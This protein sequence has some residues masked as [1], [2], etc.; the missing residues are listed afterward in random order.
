MANM[1]RIKLA[2]S[3]MAVAF[4]A[5]LA[6]G[7]SAA[8]DGVCEFDAQIEGFTASVDG[9]VQA[10][11]EL[12]AELAYA[13]AQI[14]GDDS[15]GE[16]NDA[17]SDDVTALCASASVAI[18]AQVDAGLTIVYVAP[19]CEVNFQAQ[20]SCE[21]ECTAEF[22]CEG[23]EIEARC[24][25]GEVSYTCEGSCEASGRCEATAQ[26][27][28]VA[29]EGSCSGS[30]T[31]SC[32]GT[33]NGS[34]EGTCN[35][36]CEGECSGGTDAEG[37]C[38]GE[39]TGECQ[40]SCE[41]SCSGSCGGSCMGS[42]EGSCEVQPGGVSAECEGEFRCDV[43]CDGEVSAPKCSGSVEPITCEGDAGCNA[44]CQASASADASCTE[45][46]VTVS[47]GADAEVVADI[48]ANL[49]T[50]LEVSGKLESLVGA[51]AATAQAGGRVVGE[52]T[53]GCAVT[54]ASELEAKLSAAASASANVSFSVQAS[55][56]VS[57]SA[58]GGAG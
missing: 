43:S 17:T 24:E 47:G 9:L 56:E 7:C 31:G 36:K 55:A 50:I 6:Q 35:G 37:N 58:S 19:V 26:A 54:W 4:A 46:T 18:D 16:N 15:V 52:L 1:N 28:S 11:A 51:F 38:N 27:P 23:G 40:G 34:C 12:R 29:C 5:G 8:E 49:G 14:A 33:C 41:G 2:G 10:E 25:G 32:E 45:P 3:F 57:G 30:C 44:D 13:C 21:A 20:A 42:C 39:C 22:E 48:K 53:G